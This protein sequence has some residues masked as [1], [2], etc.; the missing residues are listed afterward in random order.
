MCFIVKIIYA[1]KL[2]INDDKQR[3][4]GKNIIKTTVTADRLV[5]LKKCSYTEDSSENNEA[6]ENEL[7][8][9]RK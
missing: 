2:K 5:G 6:M 7:M 8:R 1:C 4:I 3:N 9:L